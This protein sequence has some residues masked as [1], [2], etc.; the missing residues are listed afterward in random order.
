MTAA[1]TGNQLFHLILADIAMAAATRT[2][3]P[4]F[5]PD[6]V[7]YTPGGF[8]DRWLAQAP[9]GLLKRQVTAMATAAMGSL[10]DAP[11]ERLAVLASDYGIPLAPE[12]AAAMADHFTDKRNAVLTYRR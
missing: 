12:T 1:M 10:K 6:L 3:D 7:D 4:S 2:L 9:E 5:R 8:R 11:A